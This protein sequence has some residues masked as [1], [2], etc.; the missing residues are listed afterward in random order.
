MAELEEAVSESLKLFNVV[1]IK[2]EQKRILDALTKNNDCMAILMIL[3]T[4][5]GNSLPYQLLIPVRKAMGQFEESHHM[6]ATGR[7]YEESM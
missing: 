2:Q 5:F 7:T 3:P 6:F 4:G 1:N